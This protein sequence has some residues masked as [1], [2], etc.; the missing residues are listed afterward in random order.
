M[1]HL[2]NVFKKSKYIFPIVVFTIKDVPQ[3]SSAKS[4]LTLWQS[5]AF[6]YCPPRGSLKVT[7]LRQVV[8]SWVKS[9]PNRDRNPYRNG[10]RDPDHGPDGN[11][12]QGPDRD[13]NHDC[14]PNYDNRDPDPDPARISNREVTPTATVATATVTATVTATTTA[15]LTLT[16]APPGYRFDAELLAHLYKSSG[17]SRVKKNETKKRM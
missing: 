15:T 7:T 8:R 10:N 13:G 3:K 2:Q 16:M 9:D 4:K 12:N 14:N 17:I 6:V 5:P 11:R 1:N